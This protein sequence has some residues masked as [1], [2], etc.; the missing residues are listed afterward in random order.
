VVNVLDRVAFG[1]GAK[2]NVPRVDPEIGVFVLVV[3]FVAFRPKEVVVNV[4]DGA[5]RQGPK[6]HDVQVDLAQKKYREDEEA[7]LGEKVHDEL[8]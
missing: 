2:E 5:V 7:A 6:Q 4:V 1:F 3:P 8:G